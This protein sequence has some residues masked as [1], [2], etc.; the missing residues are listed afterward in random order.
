MV[1]FNASATNGCCAIGGVI[2]INKDH[3]FTLKLNCGNGTDTKAEMIGLSCVLAMSEHF[4]F[5]EISVYGDSRVTI[6]WAQGAFNINVIT[7]H[8][9]CCRIKE[10]ILLF[11]THI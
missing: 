1:F 3:Y 6:K 5:H 11:K 9:W 10:A 8:H 7:L 4:G 2:Y